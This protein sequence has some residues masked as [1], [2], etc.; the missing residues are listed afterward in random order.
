[1]RMGSAAMTK[2]IGKSLVVNG[3]TIVTEAAWNAEIEAKHQKLVEWMRA[4]DVA[5]VLIRRNENVAW[6]TGGAVELRVLTPGETG[7]ASIL[8]TGEWRRQRFTTY[9]KRK[10]PP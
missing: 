3:E 8:V 4:E 5:G 9:R 10:P 1:M 7:V 6:V 2:R